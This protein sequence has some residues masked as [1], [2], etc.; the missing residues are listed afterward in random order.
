[1]ALTLISHTG[2]CAPVVAFPNAVHHPITQMRQRGRYPQGVV[3]LAAW[4]RRQS[5]ACMG[6]YAQASEDYS[7]ALS[8]LHRARQM[9]EFSMLLAIQYKQE[10]AAAKAR[11]EQLS[12]QGARK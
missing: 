6:S 8:N 7:A 1:M 9:G 4:K 2:A 11:M 12:L 5:A 3:S 10:M